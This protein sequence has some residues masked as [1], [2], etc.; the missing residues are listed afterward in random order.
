LAE[1][2]SVEDAQAALVQ[3]NLEL[4][5]ARVEASR[6]T[7]CTAQGIAHEDCPPTPATDLAAL[8]AG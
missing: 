6:L 4:E 7:V 8:T 2:L 1:P 3:A 5:T